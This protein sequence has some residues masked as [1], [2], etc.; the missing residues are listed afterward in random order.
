M[1]IVK[2]IKR[3]T[4]KQI[5]DEQAAIAARER[6]MFT[7][8]AAALA[9]SGDRLTITP[10]TLQLLVGGIGITHEQAEDGSVTLK[11]KWPE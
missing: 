10:D 6:L 1:T 4:R 5:V 9:Q 3:R 8:L 11:L 7:Y 2:P